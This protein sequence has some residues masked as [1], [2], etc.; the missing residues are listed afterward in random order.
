LERHY[1]RFISPIN[2]SLIVVVNLP[3]LAGVRV[4]MMLHDVD[5]PHPPLGL[6]TFSRVG[7]NVRNLSRTK[8]GDAIYHQIRLWRIITMNHPRHP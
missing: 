2:E 8:G 7:M 5:L 1:H 6:G 4:M 3:P